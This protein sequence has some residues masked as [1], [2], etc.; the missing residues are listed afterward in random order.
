MLAAASRPARSCSPARIILVLVRD[1]DYV[2][3]AE[4]IAQ[5]PLEDRAASRMLIFDR[6]TGGLRDSE[7]RSLPSLLQ[8]GDLLVLN[9]TRVLPARLFAH[10]AGIYAQPVS[11]RNPTAREHLQG[12]VEVMLTE[13]HSPSHFQQMEWSALVRPGRKLPVGERL[14][15]HA[16]Q[17]ASDRAG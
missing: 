10:R 6:A 5:Q 13:Q 17:A 14:H 9:D 4:L 16:P 11:P 7:F 2:L 15:F 12:R 8:P 3:P 1:F